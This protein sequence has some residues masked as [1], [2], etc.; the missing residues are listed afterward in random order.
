MAHAKT[1]V[2]P[3]FVAIFL[4]LIRKKSI[5]NG[6]LT[7]S[8]NKIWI[9]VCMS[10]YLFGKLLLMDLI[11]AII[12]IFLMGS[13]IFHTKPCKALEAFAQHPKLL[14]RLQIDLFSQIAFE[15]ILLRNKNDRMNTTFVGLCMLCI[16]LTGSSETWSGSSEMRIR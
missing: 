7:L 14:L 2:S 16:F 6:F 9:Y 15:V 13:F 12:I 8:A 11:N 4:L 10:A 5:A 1:S 3:A